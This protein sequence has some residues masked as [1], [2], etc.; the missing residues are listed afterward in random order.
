MTTGTDAPALYYTV[1]L[2][3]AAR[4]ALAWR[5][6]A[7][8]FT[9]GSGAIPAPV[10]DDDG[11]HHV[12]LTYAAR[13]IVAGYVADDGDKPGQ[14]WHAGIFTSDEVWAEIAAAFPRSIARAGRGCRRQLDAAFPL[15]WFTKWAQEHPFDPDADNLGD[16]YH[17]TFGT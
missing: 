8:S 9:R 14:V 12:Q 13:A 5:L 15:A 11:Y 1:R 4:V 3:H 7:Q 6:S 17:P 10:P 2:T 16:Y